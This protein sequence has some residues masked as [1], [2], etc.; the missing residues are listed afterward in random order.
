METDHLITNSKESHGQRK[1]VAILSLVIGL[2]LLVLKFYG[3]HVTG[4]KAVLSDALESIVNV[5]AGVITLIVLIIASKPADADHP[6]GHGKVESMAATFEGGAILFAGVLIIIEGIQ[7]FFKGA[8]LTE[9]N[10]GLIIITAAGLI[11]GLLGVLLA[12]QG[13]KFHSEALRSSGA[14]LLTDAYTSAGVF[15]GL[16]LVKFTGLFWLDS[17]VAL[18]FGFLL[19]FTGSKILI[20]SGNNLLD[21]HDE[22]TL[23]LLLK[24]FEKNYKVGMIHVHFTR[25]IRSGSMHHIDCHMVVPE[26]WSIDFS[27]EFIHQLEEKI[28]EDYPVSCELNIHLDPC[29][30]NYCLNCEVENCSIRQQ[31][32]SERVHF[33]L[34]EFIAPTE[35]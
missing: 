28:T 20:K 35:K 3:Y 15:V 16:L 12:N 21:A 25:V 8:E 5:V 18:L 31:A 19:A 11:N 27:H 30:R 7:S 10:L 9:L 29:R 22:E 1:K 26:F 6:Y 23:N 2:L 24:L 34:S 4:S 13:R 14:H 33:K 17:F 32:F